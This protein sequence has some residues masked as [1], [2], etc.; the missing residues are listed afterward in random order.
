MCLHELV[1]RLVGDIYLGYRPSLE[2]LVIIRLW[3]FGI[4][5]SVSVG[6][7]REGSG[8]VAMGYDVI[9]GLLVLGFTLGL[10]NFRSSVAL[11]TAPFGLRR[12]VR[13]ALISPR[14]DLGPVPMSRCKS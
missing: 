14:V 1:C 8:P 2:I 3:K 13:V 7:S 12:P 10:D 11:G 9:V 5:F 6:M 4:W